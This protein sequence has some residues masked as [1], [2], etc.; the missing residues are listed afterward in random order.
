[1]CLDIQ[2]ILFLFY[3][4]CTVRDYLHFIYSLL[5]RCTD[6]VRYYA[7]ATDVHLE[8]LP[9]LTLMPRACNNYLDGARYDKAHIISSWQQV[10]PRVAK[11]S[12]KP[13]CP[14]CF[15]LPY[16]LCAGIRQEGQIPG[17]NML[18]QAPPFL[19]RPRCIRFKAS[20]GAASPP[21]RA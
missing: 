17:C 7:I 12:P 9:G 18:G 2:T 8:R 1:M 19:L 6:E 16:P 10:L 11:R 21:A 5:F 3:V 13:S 15:I 14:P 20:N 4:Q